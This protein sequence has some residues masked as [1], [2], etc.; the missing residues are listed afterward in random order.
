MQL[1]DATILEV[2]VQLS[3]R[4]RR[5]GIPTLRNA[6]K[7]R[8]GASCGTDRL[9]KL[10]GRY[11][12]APPRLAQAVPPAGESPEGAEAFCEESPI[13]RI[14]A[15][16]VKLTEAL[17]AL[18]AQRKRAELAEAREISHQDRWAGEIYEL[19]S[20][21]RAL[22]PEQAVKDAKECA[23][24]RIQNRHLSRLVSDLQLA[25]AQVR[26]AQDTTETL[27]KS[28]VPSR[29]SPAAENGKGSS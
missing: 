22:N 19:R 15:L 24:L 21:L 12:G 18:E 14:K 16:E 8:F 11:R 23:Y 3:E 4:R 1:D 17:E 26:L 25:L 5:V 2:I 6:L 13:A 28:S 27:S 7:A 20:K 10:L 29:H 9:S